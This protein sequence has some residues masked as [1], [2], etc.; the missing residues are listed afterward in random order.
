MAMPQTGEKNQTLLV[1]VQIPYGHSL[2]ALHDL[3]V[4]NQASREVPSAVLYEQK[5]SIFTIGAAFLLSIS[6]T[7]AA[8]L[9]YNIYY[10]NPNASPPAYRRTSTLQNYDNGLLSAGLRDGEISLSYRGE[11]YTNFYTT[12]FRYNNTSQNDY[13]PVGIAQWR[14]DRTLTWQLD[15]ANNA[16]FSL[17]MAGTLVVLRVLKSDGK[18]LS[19]S[20]MVLNNG[21]YETS[22]VRMLDLFDARAMASRGLVSGGFNT[23]DNVAFASVGTSIIGVKGEQA[24]NSFSVGPAQNIYTQTNNTALSG[25]TARAGDIALALEWNLDSIPSGGHEI[26][27]RHFTFESSYA[28]LTQSLSQLVQRP[29]VTLLTEESQPSSVP[30]AATL[31]VYSQAQN[32]AVGQ[33]GYTSTYAPPSN[34]WIITDGSIDGQASY[35]LPGPGDYDFESPSIWSVTSSSKTPTSVTFSS[36]HTWSEERQSYTAAIRLWDNTTAS[37]LQGNVSSRLINVVGAEALSLSF[38]YRLKISNFTIGNQASAY[39]AFRPDNDLDSDTDSIFYI[40]GTGTLLSSSSSS[41]LLTDGAWHNTT[42]ILTTLGLPRDFRFAITIY[43]NT[44]GGG[45]TGQGNG[46]KGVVELEVDSI[47]LRIVGK[48][49]DILSMRLDPYTQTFSLNYARQGLNSPVLDP[50][51]QVTLHY[52]AAAPVPVLIGPKGLFSVRF[53]QQPS[54]SLLLADESVVVLGIQGSTFLSTSLNNVQLAAFHYNLTSGA[55]IVHRAGF[56]TVTGQASAAPFDLVITNSY[57]TL[58]VEPRDVN[59]DSVSNVVFVALDSYGREFL[60]NASTTLQTDL[61]LVP[62]SYVLQASYH[63][64]LVYTGSVDLNDDL[65]LPLELPIYRVTFIVRDVLRF[66]ITGADLRLVRDG[67]TVLQTLTDSTGQASIQLAA[68]TPYTVTV[69]YQGETIMEKG[70]TP[71]LNDLSVDLGTGYTPLVTRIVVAATIMAA[72]LA[73]IVLSRRRLKL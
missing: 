30:T 56:E 35:A 45:P 17:S 19:V 3:R 36:A 62:S 37:F 24:L 34:G 49:E 52:L 44:N 63:N 65:L 20:D 67:T 48:A 42:I 28:N 25:S 13:G 64:A 50:R 26:R 23:T 53:K 51:A 54:S 71:A 6:A 68:N 12:K 7:P 57:R 72:A 66:P 73:V 58:K 4:I 40:S 5:N 38:V 60:R 1:F 2:N 9:S 14:T 22:N 27:S 21:P 11:A 41:D 47:S 29:T 8:T 39:I 70:F 32:L 61:T 31:L 69:S 43:A 15:P 55:L 10:G 33:P 16:T 46:A 59:G 18:N